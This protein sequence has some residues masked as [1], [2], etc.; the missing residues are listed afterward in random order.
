[1]LF[2]NQQKYPSVYVCICFTFC[3]LLL[4]VKDCSADTRPPLLGVLELQTF[5][6]LLSV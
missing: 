3:S 1:M 2:K 5:P 6:C 4:S